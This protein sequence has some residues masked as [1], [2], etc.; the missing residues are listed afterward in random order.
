M[1]LKTYVPSSKLPKG[2]YIGDCIGDYYRAY[3]EDTRSLDYSSYVRILKPTL[4]PK[5]QTLNLIHEA[6]CKLG[7]SLHSKP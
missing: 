3:K 6:S 1:H 2:G 7:G 4:N 5:P